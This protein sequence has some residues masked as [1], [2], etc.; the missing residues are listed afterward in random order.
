MNVFIISDC[1][2]Y[3]LIRKMTSEID[4]KQAGS[5]PQDTADEKAKKEELV[6]ARI[7]MMRKKNEEL[8]KRQQEIEEDRRNANKYSEMVVIKKHVSG[9]LKE[10]P[11]IGRG[12]GRGLMLEEMRK[13]TLKAK[14]WEAKRRENVLKEEQERNQRSTDKTS[15]STSR[16]LADDRRVDMSRAPGRNEHSWGGVHFNKAANRKHREKEGFRSG[17][18]KGNIEMTMSGKERHQYYK[19]KEERKQIDEERK[20]RQKKAGNWSRAWDQRKVWDSRKNMWEYEDDA[21]DQ[22]E[23]RRRQPSNSSEV[24]SSDNRSKRMDNRSHGKGEQGSRQ[25]FS[26]HHDQELAAT[27]DWGDTSEKSVIQNKLPGSKTETDNKIIRNQS[28]AVAGL[29]STDWEVEI[30]TVQEKENSDIAKEAVNEHPHSDALTSQGELK[31]TKEGED[32]VANDQHTNGEDSHTSQKLTSDHPHSSAP[33][34][35][36]E[37]RQKQLNDAVVNSNLTN[38]RDSHEEQGLATEKMSTS[39]ES[40]EHEPPTGDKESKATSGH[41]PSGDSY[42]ANVEVITEDVKGTSLPVDEKQDT[43]KLGHSVENVQTSEREDN[44]SKLSQMHKANLPKLVTKVDRKV[45]F[46]TEENDVKTDSESKER[47]V[48]LDIPPTPDFLKID[49]SID[50]GDIEVDEDEVVERWS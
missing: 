27:E 45:S 40:V 6:E 8:M 38:S 21:D 46:D 2:S 5:K 33:K 14:Q 39:D 44:G 30:P 35:Q 36:R 15:S 10:S 4:Q 28:K 47:E 25:G 22:N 29:S 1:D 7:R 24:W 19:W 50:W 41:L 18:N 13:E 20:A 42:G 32:S 16:F 37:A 31:E 23:S 12:R 26:Q 17:R 49:N 34:S 3:T 43:T 11:S 48:S 9:V